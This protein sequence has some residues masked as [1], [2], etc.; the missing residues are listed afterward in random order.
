MAEEEAGRRAYDMY[1]WYVGG[2]TYDDK[3]MPTWEG[4]PEK[5]RTG[6]RVAACAVVDFERGLIENGAQGVGTE[7]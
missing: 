1:G 6:W 3:P 5:I 4:L 7:G 2:K